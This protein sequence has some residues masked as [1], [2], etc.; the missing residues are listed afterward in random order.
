M[1]WTCLTL[2]LDQSIVTIR[3]ISVKYYEHSSSE[4]FDMSAQTFGLAFLYASDRHM[5]SSHLDVRKINNWLF[6]NKER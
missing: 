2:I 5:S 6:Q 4:V 1:Q 3:D